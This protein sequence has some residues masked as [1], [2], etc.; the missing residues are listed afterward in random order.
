[1]AAKA[2][3]M[4]EDAWDLLMV[5]AWFGLVHVAVAVFAVAVWCLPHPA[6]CAVLGAYA[7]AGLWPNAPPTRGGAC[8]S[9][10]P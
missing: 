4:L 8:A 6:A 5:T 7:V 10:A 2:P 1:M 3:S 9:R